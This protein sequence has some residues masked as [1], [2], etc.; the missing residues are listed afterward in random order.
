M[1]TNDGLPGRLH[2]QNLQPFTLKPVTATA[3]AD[4]DSYRFP[5]TTKVPASTLP[6]MF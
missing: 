5:F 2:V 3:A 4:G 1:D 6:V